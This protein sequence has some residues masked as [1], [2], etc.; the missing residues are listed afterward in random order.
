MGGGGGGGLEA[1]RLSQSLTTV[2]CC[3]LSGQ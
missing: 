1:E 3:V 2:S